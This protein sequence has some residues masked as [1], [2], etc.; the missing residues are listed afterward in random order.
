MKTSLVVTL[1][2][3]T[4]HLAVF[5]HD[6]TTP[7]CHRK[8]DARKTTSSNVPFTISDAIVQSGYKDEDEVSAPV[9]VKGFSNEKVSNS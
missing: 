6:E 2:F 5:L 3:Q 9:C 1:I 7:R 4:R 8:V